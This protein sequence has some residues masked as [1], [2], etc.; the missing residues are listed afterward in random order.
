MSSDGEQN[1]EKLIYIIGWE[2]MILAALNEN[3]FR[4]RNL[5]LLSLIAAPLYP[6]A[7]EFCELRHANLFG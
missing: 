4:L 5:Q 7:R 6:F 2:E 1:C 3:T